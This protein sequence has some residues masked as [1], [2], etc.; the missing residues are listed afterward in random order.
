MKVIV[1][2]DDGFFDFYYSFFIHFR[3]NIVLII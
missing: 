2:L 1:L 3:A